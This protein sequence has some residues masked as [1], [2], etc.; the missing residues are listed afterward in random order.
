[1]TE[2]KT[3]R[4]DVSMPPLF[5][6]KGKTALGGPVWRAVQ[7][8]LLAALFPF[9]ALAAGAGEPIGLVLSGGG[10]KGAYE[11]GVWQAMEEMGLAGDVK[12]ISGTSVGAIN[13]ALF[14][15]RPESAETLWLEN[16]QDIFSLST[17]RIGKDVQDG[18]D[19]ASESVEIAKAT[20]EDWKG[21]VHFVLSVAIR[22][23]DRAVEGTMTDAEC[24]GYID[25][26]KLEVALN[27][28]LPAEWPEGAPAVYVTAVDKDAGDASVARLDAWPH[29]RRV[30]LVRASA[31][32]PFAFDT[33]RIDGRTLVDGGFETRG[34]D[35]VPLAP[36]L[37][38]H[39]EIKTVIVVYLADKR[40]LDPERRPANTALAAAKGVR[41][42][43][44][45]PSENI[46]GAFKGW[47]G[48]FDARPATA[49]RLMNLGRAD[50][51][52]AL[53]AGWRAF[54]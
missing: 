52:K 35:K 42:V 32:L 24:T 46:G 49:R 19:I 50:A 4:I 51:R 41:L 13:A 1:M 28:N 7:K 6:F 9:V 47:Q 5:G 20:G 25:S 8:M 44:I 12:A 23:A 11:V 21:W 2:R 10:A 43:E 33:V 45:I 53:K 17:N 29:E 26:S 14:A 37:D 31:A 34:G 36:I 30:E 54:Q 18:M 22:I 48:V 16:M 27:S 15:T 39:P 3:Q 38:N 40:N